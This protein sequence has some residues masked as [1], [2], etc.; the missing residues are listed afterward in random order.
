[1]DVANVV[2]DVESVGNTLWWMWK[3]LVTPCKA[4][5]TC[6]G[7]STKYYLLVDVAS[8]VVDVAHI[9]MDVASVGNTLWCTHVAFHIAVVLLFDIIWL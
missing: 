6:W 7:A 1:M 2:M 9:V 4:C 3:V 8:A 5:D